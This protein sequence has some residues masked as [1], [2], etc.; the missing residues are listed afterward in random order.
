MIFHI[1]FANTISE[2]DLTNR[3]MGAYFRRAMREGFRPDQPGSDI[4]RDPKGR[5]VVVLYTRYGEQARYV[6]TGHK[7]QAIPTRNEY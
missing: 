2:D 7:L 6:W 3:A 4:L 1:K 5:P